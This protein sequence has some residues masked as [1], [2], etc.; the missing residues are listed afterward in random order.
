MSSDPL[1]INCPTHGSSCVSAVVC[2]HMVDSKAVAVGFVENNDDPSDLQ[3]WCEDCEA[4][5]LS[6]GDK[7]QAFLDFNRMTLVCVN[8]YQELKSRHSREF[9][10]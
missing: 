8:C 7:T 4:M 10:T 6:E 1:T 5:F 9:N 3:A 2:G